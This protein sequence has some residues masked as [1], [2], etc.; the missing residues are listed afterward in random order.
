M[1]DLRL[2]LT[3][4]AIASLQPAS[5]G[6]YFVRDTDLPG[7]MV[8]VGKRRKTFVV[9]GE[10]KKAGQRLS[11]RMK[12][13]EVGELATR[14]ARAKAKDIL[15][16]I[17]SGVDPRASRQKLDAD[18]AVDDLPSI[19]NPT[20]RIAWERYRDGHMKKKGRSDGTINNYRDHV[21]RLLADWLD[22]PLSKFGDDPA[23]VT[24]RHE[25]LT[26]SNGAYIANGC[27]RTLRAV[28]NH[29][30]KAA[31]SL[32]ADNPVLAIDWNAEHRRNT[33]LGLSDLEGWFTQ[34]KALKNPVRREFHLF[35]LLSGHRPEAIRKARVEHVDF[36]ARVLHIPRP[37]GGEMKAFDIPLSHGMIRCLVRVMRIGRVLYEK[38]S[39]DWLF[40]ADSESGH[41]VEHKENRDVL[42]KWGNDLRQ[43][44]RTIAQAAGVAELDVHL[45]MNHS[46]PGVNAGYITRNKLLSDHLRQQQEAISRRMLEAGR[47]CPSDFERRIA[48]WPLLPSGRI[49]DE[50]MS[51]KA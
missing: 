3:D 38:Q 2:A 48:G 22:E 49:L 44:F 26:E 32:P 6:Q 34:L 10:R 16:K 13:A 12:V 27:M 42:S 4:R 15:G 33:A 47:S 36:R 37:K 19:G 31:R 18:T 43:T 23:L 29:A 35:M 9:Q 14:A 1:T 11:V 30:R 45:L 51:D 25:K 17:A 46:I 50:L 40:P 39:R 41:M 8:L 21:E 7:F 20:L 28:Y 5:S 24:A